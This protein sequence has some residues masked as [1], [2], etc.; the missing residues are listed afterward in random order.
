MPDTGL[1]KVSVV[2]NLLSEGGRAHIN[3]CET[4]K[5]QLWQSLLAQACVIHFM[6]HW[7]RGIYTLLPHCCITEGYTVCLMTHPLWK[8]VLLILKQCG[9]YASVTFT[10]RE[11]NFLHLRER[12]GRTRVC[13]CVY[14]L[15]IHDSLQAVT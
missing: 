6:W 12:H 13:V 9:L 14:T 5:P 2:P 11:G 10:H 15:T 8:Y 1:L 3:T 7:H 4:G